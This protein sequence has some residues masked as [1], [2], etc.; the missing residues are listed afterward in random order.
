M[1]H[2]I[3]I[4]LIISLIDTCAAQTKLIAHKSHSGNSLSFRE[5]LKS[6]NPALKTSNFGDIPQPEIKTARLDS[7]IFVNDTC[8]IMVTTEVCTD[9]FGGEAIT[10]E[11]NHQK[12]G[13]QKAIEVSKDKKSSVWKS[14]RDTVY[15]HALFSQNESLDYV[16]TTL[17]SRYHFVNKAECAVFVGYSNNDKAFTP[18]K[19]SILVRVLDAKKGLFELVLNGRFSNFWNCYQVYSIVGIEKK[20]DENSTWVSIQNPKENNSKYSQSSSCELPYTQFKN[21]TIKD[22]HLFLRNQRSIKNKLHTIELPGTYRLFVEIHDTKKTI[23]SNEF[24]IK[25]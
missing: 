1:K 25:S 23:Y 24:T 19:S 4:L 6:N 15:H 7:L 12:N 18:S 9:R 13:W 14:G 20:D 2:T 17:K 3:L 11:W 8:Q 10:Q 22:F 16:R 21:E 5:L